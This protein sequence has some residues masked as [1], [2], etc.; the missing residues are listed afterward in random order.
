M[1]FHEM[2]TKA[3]LVSGVVLLI[4]MSILCICLAVM[5]IRKSTRGM[6]PPP[7]FSTEI[8]NAFDSWMNRTIQLFMSRYLNDKTNGEM[9]SEE[10]LNLHSEL[11][12]NG[13]A[14]VTGKIVETMPR[15]YYTY[16]TRFYG[17]NQLSIVIYETV[18]LVFVK[19]IENAIQA[20]QRAMAGGPLS[21]VLNK[22]LSDNNS[23]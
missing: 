21:Q 3:L 8:L 13:I 1:M 15:Y 2:V 14:Y 22:S 16:M 10:E 4:C 9:V 17:D 12:V 19:Y 23:N 5:T 20:R 7:P 11:V 18:R 6:V